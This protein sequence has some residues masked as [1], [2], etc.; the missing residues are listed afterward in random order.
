MFCRIHGCSSAWR[1]SPIALEVTHMLCPHVF[2]AEK[3]QERSA[4]RGP[5]H[6]GTAVGFFAFDN[7]HDSSDDH[8]GLARGFNRVDG[9]G[10]GGADVV[11]DNDAG[12]FAAEAFN[13]AACAVLLLGLADEEAVKEG[14]AGL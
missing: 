11:D 2:G 8:A 9:G 1:P 12:A 10:A 4:A 5:F 3:A 7:T 13:A 6:C 14:S